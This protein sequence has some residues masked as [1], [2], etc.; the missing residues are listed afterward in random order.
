MEAAYI[1]LASHDTNMEDGAEVVITSPSSNFLSP[2]R[3]K[4]ESGRSRRCSACLGPDHELPSGERHSINDTS[5]SLSDSSASLAADKHCHERK[6]GPDIDRKARRKLLI[7]MALSLTFM[8]GE[9]TGGIFAGSLAIVSDAAHL[10]TDFAS[11]LIS[12]LALYLASRRATKKLSFGW[13]RAEILGALMSILFLW[14]I[15]GVLV[16]MGVER[17]IKQ[18][19]TV[20]ATV[21]LITAGCGVA[22]NILM[23]FT[24]HPHGHHHSHGNKNGNNARER[25]NSNSES[26]C[27]KLLIGEE[28]AQGSNGYMTYGTIQTGTGTSHETGHRKDNINVKAAFIH[29]IGDLLQSV[30]VLIAAL[31]IYFKPEWKL[32]DPICTF[33]FSVFVLITTLTIMRD[34]LVVLMEGTPRGLDFAEIRQSFYDIKEVK[35]I[36]DLRVWSLS[37]DKTALS[38]HI[39]VEKNADTLEILKQATVMIQSRFNIIETTIQVEE[40]VDDMLDCTHCQDLPD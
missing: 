28:S 36:H 22:F 19:F 15:T 20:D 17:C 2:G 10:L 14:V 12:L 26:D 30:G 4:Q 24:L 6:T 5:R 31:I 18:D 38:V 35:D 27:Q 9:V 3:N 34:I 23:G 33:L 8:I 32:A 13:Y 16:Y 37:M 39:A 11:F 21:M 40:Y 25:I 29:V 1:K 7:A